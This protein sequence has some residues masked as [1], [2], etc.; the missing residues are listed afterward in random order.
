MKCLYDGLSPLLVVE[1]MLFLPHVVG[2]L[3]ACPD[4]AKQ[5]TRVAF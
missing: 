1:L 5:G 2:Q 3:A 4:L